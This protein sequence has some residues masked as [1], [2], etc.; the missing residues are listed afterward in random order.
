MGIIKIIGCPESVLVLHRRFW[1]LGLVS[2]LAH[3]GCIQGGY[4][5]VPRPFIIKSHHTIRV[6]VLLKLIC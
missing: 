5:H 4:L 3:Y 2:C 6:W 1:P